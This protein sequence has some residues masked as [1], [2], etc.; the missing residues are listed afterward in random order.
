MTALRLHSYSPPF[1][2]LGSV[3][4]GNEGVV[5]ESLSDC[6]ELVH[7]TWLATSISSCFLKPQDGGDKP[8]PAAPGITVGNHTEVCHEQPTPHHP[9]EY[10]LDQ[11]HATPRSSYQ[12]STSHR[13]LSS[14][15]QS[16][17]LSESRL[18]TSRSLSRMS[19]TSR[20]SAPR[21]PTIGAPS[22]F[23]RVQS[24]RVS[25][26][27]RSPA[28][29]PLQLSIYLPGNELPDLPIFWEDGA[30]K[31]ED[32]TVERPVQALVKSRSDSM[33]LR[34]PSSSFSIPRKPVPSRTSSLDASRF[35]MDSQFTLNWVGGPTKSRSI[36]HLRSKSIERRPSFMT[37]RSAQDFLDALDARDAHS[38]QPPPPAIRSN[39]EPS[40]T[41]YRRAS[42]QSLRLRTHLE[43]RQSL[44]ARLPNCA[45]IQEEISPLSPRPGE[46]M[47]LSPISDRDDNTDSSPYDEQPLQLQESI[48]RD[49]HAEVPVMSKARSSSGSSTLLNPPTPLLDPF[50]PD[51]AM[52][53]RPIVTT[54]ISGNTHSSFRDRFSQ[55]IL[56]ALPALPTVERSST[57]LSMYDISGPTELNSPWSFPSPRPHTKQSSMS[58]SW[59][60]GGGRGASFDVEKTPLPPQV[61]SVGVAF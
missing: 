46:Q 60:L 7:L 34:H 51:T 12:Q 39:S 30:D 56:K 24:G 21:R 61:A 5:M 28:F 57:S 2:A 17:W 29:R 23:R 1:Q 10:N 25:P 44:E 58:S 45:T 16:A 14:L 48:Q 36:D 32:V 9:P 50:R 43:E 42:E 15:R 55:W 18:R 49:A 26:L 4:T 47:P 33:L 41:I 52:N 40:Y 20:R 11:A 53:E 37:T 54:T 3:N 13:P 31:V 38:P 59:T 35:S 22:E 8:E 6:L 27:R 19:F